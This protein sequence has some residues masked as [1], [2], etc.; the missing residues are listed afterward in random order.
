MNEYVKTA[1]TLLACIVLLAVGVRAASSI[2]AERDRQTLDGLL[3]SPLTGGEIIFAKW[4]GSIAAMRRPLILLAV[5]WFMGVWSGGL[6]WLAVPILML[7]LAAYLGWMA[8][9][10]ILCAVSTRNTLRAVMAAQ[11]LAMFVGCGPWIG[12]WLMTTIISRGGMFWVAFPVVLTLSIAYALLVAGILLAAAMLLR[13]ALRPRLGAVLTDFLVF[14]CP[15]V[16]FTDV[17]G[18]ILPSWRTTNVS[19]LMAIGLTPPAVLHLFTF[20]GDASHILYMTHSSTAPQIA[21]CVAGVF[22]FVVSGCVLGL[23]AW[24]RFHRT[25][26]RTDARRHRAF[27]RPR[28]KVAAPR[29]QRQIR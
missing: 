7:F 9:L 3:A 4:W 26:G 28:R 12:V 1:G 15:L 21:F 8:S 14:A 17:L 25:C 20:Y 16:A 27:A 24:D 18:L 5:I 2:G 23:L 22:F 13:K 6:H 11:M 29:K 19:E 10:G